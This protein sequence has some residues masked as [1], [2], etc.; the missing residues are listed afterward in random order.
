MRIGIDGEALRSPLSGV[1][2]Y[3]YNLC[4]ELELLLP[5]AV[6]LAYSRL[7]ASA[8][9]LPSARWQLRR[10]PLAAFRRLPSFVWL[11]SRGRAMCLADGIDVFWAGRTLHPGLGDK[12]RTIVTIHDLN[13]LLWPKTMQLSTR[14][15]HKLWFRHDVLSAQVRLANSDSTA[16]RVRDLICTSVDAVVRPGVGA[17]FCAVPDQRTL[18]DFRSRIGVHGPY[19]L[20][21]ANSEPRKNLAVLVDAF[22]GLKK[23]GYLRDHALLL[24]GDAGWK[25]RVSKA[26]A[27]SARSC[28]VIT[29]GYLPDELMPSLYAAADLFVMPS[30]YEGFGMPLLEAR[31]CGTRLVATDIPELH[32][33][34]ENHCVFVEPTVDGV[35]GGILSASQSQPPERKSSAPWSAEYSWQRAALAML[36]FLGAEVVR[37]RRVQKLLQL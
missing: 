4:R 18:S 36:P 31:V 13:H 32:E 26:K 8:L 23:R 15:S 17:H 1:G 34:G 5:T 3:V 9:R 28:N 30:L 6:F 11:K 19:I 16:M 37:E 29:L 10:E 12:A 25:R 24:V 21:V 14:W 33:S 27:E 35:S 20:S 2:Q 7:P 22:I